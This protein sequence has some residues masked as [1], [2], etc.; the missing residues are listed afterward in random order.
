M[1]KEEFGD[2]KYG[3]FILGPLLS[4]LVYTLYIYIYI[5]IEGP[6]FGSLK[7]N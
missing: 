1:R 6:Y 7:R 2:L 3:P 5:Y 4:F